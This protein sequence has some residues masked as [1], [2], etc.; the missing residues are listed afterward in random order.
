MKSNEIIRVQP[1]TLKSLNLV[2]YKIDQLDLP[3]VAKQAD[4]DVVAFH[5]KR[6]S[7]RNAGKAESLGNLIHS[8]IAYYANNQS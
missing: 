5:F 2:I 1:A 4:E 7:K 8:L 6:R 3:V